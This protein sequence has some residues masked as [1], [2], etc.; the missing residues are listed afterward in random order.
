MRPSVDVHH[1]ENVLVILPEL[2]LPSVSMEEGLLAMTEPWIEI[3]GEL[4]VESD[5]KALHGVRGECG[6]VTRN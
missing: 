1:L 2:S 4:T 6:G 3:A 5:R